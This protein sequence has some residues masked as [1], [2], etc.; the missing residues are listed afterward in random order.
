MKKQSKDFYIWTM[1]ECIKTTYEWWGTD[2]M[3]MYNNI[4]KD[5]VNAAEAI[6]RMYGF[7]PLESVNYK[8]FYTAKP[9]TFENPEFV[10]EAISKLIPEDKVLRFDIRTKELSKEY[11]DL[12]MCSWGRFVPIKR[13]DLI[14]AILLFTEEFILQKVSSNRVVFTENKFIV[15]GDFVT[16]KISKHGKKTYVSIKVRGVM[17]L[18]YIITE[19][20]AV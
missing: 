10:Y 6:K 11:K 20:I 16:F 5:F 4:R 1:A 15:Y 19:D 9:S 7:E 12:N 2:M 8:E 13:V 18:Q 14:M 17:F 3:S